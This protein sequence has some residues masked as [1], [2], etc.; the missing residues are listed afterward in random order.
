MNVFY[1]A[2]IDSEEYTNNLK[3]YKND[4]QHYLFFYKKSSIAEV[5]NLTLS[6][7]QYRIVSAK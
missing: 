5:S 1:N 4:N 2:T 7:N 6:K 3:N